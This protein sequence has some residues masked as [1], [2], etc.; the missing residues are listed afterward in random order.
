M[1]PKEIQIQ[2]HNPFRIERNAGEGNNKSRSSQKKV[3][4]SVFDEKE[5]KGEKR[6]RV[7]AE[8]VRSGGKRLGAS[9]ARDSPTDTF[10]RNTLGARPPPPDQARAN[11]L[12]HRHR[13]PPSRS[14]SLS[15]CAAVVSRPSS[16]HPQPSSV[17]VHSAHRCERGSAAVEPLQR[18]SLRPSV[19]GHWH[20]TP[21]TLV[22]PPPSVPPSFR[23]NM[24]AA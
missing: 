23:N 19:P 24:P 8:E 5:E 14:A 18:R 3:S 9:A 4:I 10:L 22:C 2:N 20:I 7:E 21:S 15:A 17:A 12:S 1:H 6:G 11:N 13:P 16:L